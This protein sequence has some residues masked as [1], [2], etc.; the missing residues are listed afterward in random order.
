[1]V[2][3]SLVKQSQKPLRNNTAVH[4]NS[5]D[6]HQYELKI[7]YTYTYI[8]TYIK[9]LSVINKKKKKGSWLSFWILIAKLLR[10]SRKVMCN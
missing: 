3:G 5:Y 6:T 1:M 7:L 9:N 4:I 8:H 2:K 10:N